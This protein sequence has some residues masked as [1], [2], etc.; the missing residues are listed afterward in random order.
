MGTSSPSIDNTYVP[1]REL[2]PYERE[3]LLNHSKF[4]FSLY[5]SLW[6]FLPIVI[7]FNLIFL[8]YISTLDKEFLFGYILIL[9]MEIIYLIQIMNHNKLYLDARSP[10]FKGIGTIYFIQ[11]QTKNLFSNKENNTSEKNYALVKI[12][13]KTLT[14]G[15]KDIIDL[16]VGD[17]LEIEFSP[18]TNYVW[19]SKKIS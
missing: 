18:Y 1:F 15:N 11:E 19:S 5:R 12:G 3:Q 9:L 7:G 16:K 6:I 13:N 10:V 14:L 4:L 8:K 2:A 17:I